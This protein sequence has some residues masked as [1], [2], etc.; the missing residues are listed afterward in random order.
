MLSLPIALARPAQRK[1]RLSSAR[2][3]LV[4]IGVCVLLVAL[5]A[6]PAWSQDD[7][8]PGALAEYGSTV[9]NRALMGVTS[10]VT[11]PADPVM[12]VVEPREEFERL[13]VAVVTSRVVGLVQ[14]T[15]LGAY[16][17]GMGTLDLL[18]APLTPMR[19][20]SP[21]PR[22]QLFEGVEHEWY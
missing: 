13:P 20:L 5:L 7:D 16:R 2:A 6:L 18:F 19:M 8:E 11:S 12:A 3:S 21:E 1:V 14:G 10:L 15:L 22:Y 17:L 9:A 4:R